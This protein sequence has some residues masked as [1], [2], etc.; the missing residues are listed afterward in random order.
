MRQID[1]FVMIYYTLDAYWQDHKTDELTNICSFMCPFTFTGIG[2]AIPSYYI[3]FCEM[4][5]KENYSVEEGY[6]IMKK[7]VSTLG[8]EEAAKQ[9]TT[10]L[11]T[12][13]KMH[14]KSTLKTRE[15]KQKCGFAVFCRIGVAKVEDFG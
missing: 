11:L 6:E 9:L 15:D 4:F 14:T 10:C 7:Y 1:V 13:L 12:L 2:S 3:E 5:D 8:S